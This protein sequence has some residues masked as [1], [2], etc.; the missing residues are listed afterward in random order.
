M[1]KSTD[2]VKSAPN[3]GSITKKLA[4]SFG[5]QI[6]IFLFGFISQVILANGLGADGKGTFSLV[7]LIVSLIFQFSNG[8]LGSANAHFTGRF[9]K[10]AAGILGNSLTIALLVGGGL[11][12]IV[13]TQADRLLPIIYP[14]V[15]TN[16]VRMTILSLTALFLLEYCNSIVRG[17]NRIARFS[18]TLAARELI[19]VLIILVLFL[20]GSFT[21]VNSLVSWVVVAV[22]ISLYAF[23]SAW[24]GMQFR[25][26]PDFRLW[27]TMARYSAKAHTANLS[28]F[29]RMRLD[30]FI[31]AYFLDVKTVGYYSVS[32]AIVQFL[33]F[34]PKS[35]GQVLGPHIAWHKDS[36]GNMIT[37]ILCRISL[38]LSIISGFLLIIAGY[39]GIRIIFGVEFLPSYRPLVIMIPGAVVYTL[40][41]S[42]AGDLSG[43]GKPQYAMKI[44]LLM[45]VL[46]VGINVT[47]IPSLGMVGAAL[48]ASIT[49]TITGLLFLRA[50]LKVSKVPILQAIFIRRADFS[51]LLKAIRRL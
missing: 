20:T 47:L 4:A 14:D 37:P 41:T 16:L 39:F 8:S 44:S 22:I 1:I 12:W 31:L 21:I 19:F 11:T 27:K 51:L 42:L 24:S 43:R 38:F 2:E 45:L 33:S 28:S 50:F 40:A 7:L 3:K 48:S 18:F 34:L 23:W 5:G 36:A 6:S 32:F 17:Q 13:I 9:S 26:K 46:N 29:L 10:N 49:Q 25:I 35:V 15:S 30:M